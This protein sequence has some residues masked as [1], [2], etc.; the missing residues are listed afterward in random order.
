MT[1]FVFRTSGA[2]GTGSEDIESQSTPSG[3]DH[4]VPWKCGVNSQQF[5]ETLN[6]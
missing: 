4:A 6:P 5:L 3:A 1:E 2:R